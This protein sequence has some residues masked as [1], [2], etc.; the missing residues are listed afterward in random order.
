MSIP[1]GDGSN[2]V[3]SLEITED[4]IVSEYFAVNGYIMLISSSSGFGGMIVVLKESMPSG[5]TAGVWF[6]PIYAEEGFEFSIEKEG[7]LK[8]LENKFMKTNFMFIYTIY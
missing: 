6:V 7:Y 2:E 4:Y 3:E 8:K 1:N 5:L